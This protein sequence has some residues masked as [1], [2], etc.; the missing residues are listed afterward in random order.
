ME[1]FNDK[2][3]IGIDISKAKLDIKYDEHQPVVTI[4]NKKRV[5][6]DL[7]Q[8][9]P[10]DK[11]QVLVLLEA[12]GG[13]E[14]AIVKWLLSHDIPVAII[15]AKR[16]RDFAKSSGE[17]AKN[18]HIDAEMI[19]RYGQVF[20]DKIHLE[21]EKDALEEKI[22]DLNRRRNQLVSLHNTEKRH[23]ATIQNTQGRQSIERMIKMLDKE[24]NTIEEKL[25]QAL[26]EDEAIL[27]KAKLFMTTKGVGLIT[28]YT[29]IGE[30][31]E[32]GKVNNRKIA[33][34]AGIAPYCDDSGTRKGKRRIFGGRSLVRSALYMAVLSAKKFNPAIKVFY[35]RLIV[36]GK[37]RKVAMVACMRKLLTILNVM[38][39]NNEPWQEKFA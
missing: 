26:Q 15:N 20:S 7:K 38:V 24:L 28:A 27:N 32:L 31:P 17:F 37:P 22:E 25:Q 29:L 34:L 10:K 2:I 4:E 39:K 35:E 3:H 19:R 33:A 13:Y 9:L 11:T 1:Q 30:L 14:K 6:K 18:D 8:Y 23:L 36:R 5:F 16:V 12:T 21:K